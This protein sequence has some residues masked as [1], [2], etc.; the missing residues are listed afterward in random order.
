MYYS[1]TPVLFEDRLD[2]GRQLAAQLQPLGLRW[3]D[4]ATSRGRIPAAALAQALPRMCDLPVLSCDRTDASELW[5]NSRASSS[6][7]LRESRAA[8]NTTC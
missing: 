2:A 7:R 1:S 8:L 5:A 3:P 4:L 6:C